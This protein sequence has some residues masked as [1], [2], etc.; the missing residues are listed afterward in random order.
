[1]QDEVVAFALGEL[2]LDIL[3]ALRFCQILLDGWIGTQFQDVTASLVR[4][5]ACCA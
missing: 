3:F 4:S 1:M 2:G 5:E